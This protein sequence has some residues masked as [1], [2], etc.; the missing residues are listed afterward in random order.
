[1]WKQNNCPMFQLF[2]TENP[3]KPTLFVK[4]PSLLSKWSLKVT[5]T[6]KERAASLLL[7]KLQTRSVKYLRTKKIVRPQKPGPL[8]T[9]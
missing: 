2:L 5:L 1:M 8:R 4:I 3:T 6:T 7:R 9:L